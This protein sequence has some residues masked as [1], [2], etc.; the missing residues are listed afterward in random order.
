M[1][2]RFDS[3]GPDALALEAMLVDVNRRLKRGKA[4]DEGR[5]QGHLVAAL[6]GTEVLSS[7]SRRCDT[8]L[9]RRVTLKDQA[10]RKIEQTQIRDRQA[11][12]RWDRG[13]WLDHFEVTNES[14]LQFHA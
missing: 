11:V 8:C 2:E 1:I 13:F 10:G 14:Y 4:F 9:E 7:F 6:D 5:V 3:C 12:L